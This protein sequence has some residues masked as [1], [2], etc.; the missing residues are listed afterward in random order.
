MSSDEEKFIVASRAVTFGRHV[1]VKSYLLFF[2]FSVLFQFLFVL[3]FLHL[4]S[5]YRSFTN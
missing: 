5:F 4:S 2:V 3:F 1:S